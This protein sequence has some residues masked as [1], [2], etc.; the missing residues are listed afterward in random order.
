MNGSPAVI[1]SLLLAVGCAHE[2]RVDRA[3]DGHV[4]EGRYVEPEA[5]ASFLRGAIAES[6]GNARDALAAYHEATRLDPQAAEAWTRIGEVLCRANPRDGHADEALARALSIAHDYARAWEAT[7]RCAAARGD[8]TAAREAA[9]RAAA[10]DASS[11]AANALLS[12]GD[13]A[14]AT[15]VARARLVSL[16]ATARDPAAAWDALAAWA[17]A[18]GDVALWARAVIQ[19]APL[20]PGRRDAAARTAEMFAG[21]GHLATAREV[22]AAAARAAGAPLVPENHPLA[23]RLALDEAIARGDAGEVRARATRVRLSLEEAA[24]RAALAAH[25][26]LAREL[27]TDVARADSTSTGAPLVL[28]ATGGADGRSS[29]VGWIARTHAV[30]GDDLVTRAAVDLAA[31]G[32][33]DPGALTADG[34]VEL[35]VRRST[36]PAESPS[37]DA[38]HALLAAAFLRPNAPATRALAARLASARGIDPIVDAASILVHPDAASSRAALDAHPG[39]P[40]VAAAVLRITDAVAEGDI[41]RR[42]RTVLNAFGEP[43]LRH[44]E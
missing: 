17:Q 7:A 19:L 9:R 1:L 4:V 24:A 25:N 36:P 35:G 40:L 30:A 39:D 18:H 12:R 13:T 41:A 6:A 44:R 37:L 43:A 42:A 16:T 20:A 23:A 26:D 32:V 33:L 3:Y 22:A 15:A 21:A 29:M 28:A 11:D 2:P 27:A 34:A 5:Y 8:D 10:L 14:D 38:R 31:R